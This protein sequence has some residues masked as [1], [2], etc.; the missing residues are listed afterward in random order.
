ML[1]P[2]Q[3]REEIEILLSSE[4]KRERNLSRF[5]LIGI[6]A[7]LMEL[8]G[9][10]IDMT[11]SIGS[12]M[13][14]LAGVILGSLITAGGGLLRARWQQDAADTRKQAGY[15]LERKVNAL[16]DLYSQLEET[17]R[18]LND[19]LGLEPENEDQYWEDVRPKVADF[20]NALRQYGIFLSEEQDEILHEALGQ[21]RQVD[22]QI[23]A[24]VESN[25]DVP[26]HLRA[27]LHDFMDA[28]Q[29]ARSALKKELNRP[30]E[31]L[32]E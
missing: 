32:E 19:N 17:H 30:I 29:D 23:Q 5:A 6:T 14:G 26:D 11:N 15:F 7:T 8:G 10:S 22:I 2:V 28:Y 4:E 3:I 12:A 31:E 25:R 21:F 9:Q 13:I 1:S 27:D 18:A 20:R 24:Q 16:T